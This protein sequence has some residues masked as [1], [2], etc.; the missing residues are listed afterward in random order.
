MAVRIAHA[1]EA[2]H[3]E[4]S[5]KAEIASSAGTLFWG[6]EATIDP[7][8]IHA[9]AS[10]V[11]PTLMLCL[12]AAQLLA[13]IPQNARMARFVIAACLT[14]LWPVLLYCLVQLRGLHPYD[15]G[16]IAGTVGNAVAAGDL[17]SFMVLRRFD[18]RWTVGVQG[19]RA[20]GR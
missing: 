13:T 14:T 16:Y 15:A 7:Y 11:L 12:G 2:F 20:N 10:W 9:G 4:P 18:A 3:R 6:A 5:A 17:L 19:G 1:W 8:V